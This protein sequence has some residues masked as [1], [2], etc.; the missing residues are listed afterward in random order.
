MKLILSIFLCMYGNFAMSMDVLKI[1]KRLQKQ[2][3]V[4][5]KPSHQTKK[6][7]HIYVCYD[8]NGNKKEYRFSSSNKLR[9]FT[10]ALAIIEND[11]Q[12]DTKAF[13]LT[14]DVKAT[15]STSVPN[16]PAQLTLPQL[17]SPQQPEHY[18]PQAFILTKD[19]RDTPTFSISSVSDQTEPLTVS[20]PSSPQQPEYYTPVVTPPLLLPFDEEYISFS[21]LNELFSFA[22]NINY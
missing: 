10:E 11:Y 14:K 12:P 13:L 17:N 1:T 19:P 20:Q 3:S 6:K 16:Q 4:K 8:L 15:V 2:S 21:R 9:C 5:K 22:D 7:E 18:M